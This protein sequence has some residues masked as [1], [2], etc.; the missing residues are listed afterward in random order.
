MALNYWHTSSSQNTL[1]ELPNVAISHPN[2]AISKENIAIPQTNV[3]ILK[4]NVAIS[5]RSYFFL[6]V[7]S[8][9]IIWKT[10]KIVIVIVIKCTWLIEAFVLGK[11][12]GASHLL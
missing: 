10:I 11:M 1:G 8:F 6:L 7:D 12:L 9:A 5:T 3:A 4:K 2:I